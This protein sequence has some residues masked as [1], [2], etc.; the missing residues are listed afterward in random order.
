[1]AEALDHL[2]AVAVL[3]R[4]VSFGALGNAGPW[5][6]ELIA[7]LAHYGV[8]VPVAG[9]VYGIGGREFMPHEI[10]AVYRDLLE[11]AET[12]QVV[13]SVQHLGVRE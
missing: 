4:S 12:G 2:K 10:E 8:E 13:H 3:D 6:L 11:T 5:Y 9:C 7:A 1:M